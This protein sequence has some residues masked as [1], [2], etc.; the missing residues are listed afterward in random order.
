MNLKIGYSKSFKTPALWPGI[1]FNRRSMNASLHLE[2][3]I[4]CF[5]LTSVEWF[6]CKCWSWWLWSWMEQF[7]N[8]KLSKAGQ[9]R[10]ISIM[11]AWSVNCST[12][13]NFSWI[14]CA[15]NRRRKLRWRHPPQVLRTR[16]FLNSI[17]GL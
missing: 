4:N 14:N 7:C 3:M 15:P 2:T 5:N 17:H 16:R 1:H 12:C 10:N 11:L 8:S 9:E 13:T 6:H